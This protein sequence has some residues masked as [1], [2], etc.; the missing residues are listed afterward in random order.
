MEDKKDN[1]KTKVQELEPD[2]LEKINGGN[3]GWE[4]TATCPIC[5]AKCS[6]PGAV[7]NHIRDKHP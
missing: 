7:M 1:R 2:Q 5:G 3:F 4:L 6:G